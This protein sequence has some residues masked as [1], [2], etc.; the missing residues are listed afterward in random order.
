MRVEIGLDGALRYQQPVPKRHRR[1]PP[2]LNR[3]PDRDM[4]HAEPLANLL[5]GIVLLDH[6]AALQV[7][8]PKKITGTATDA[9]NSKK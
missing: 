3:F 4:S 5:T 9:A 7:A 8:Q 1:Q 2:F 6:R